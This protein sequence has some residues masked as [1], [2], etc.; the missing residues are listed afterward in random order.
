MLITVRVSPGAARDE[1]TGIKDGVWQ[2]K[3]KAPPEAGKANY[4]LLRLLGK[5]LKLKSSDLD[6]VRGHTSRHKRVAV[7]GLSEAEVS[8]RLSSSSAG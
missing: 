6:I 8:E 1:I 2:I 5:A 3:V 4:A 7:I